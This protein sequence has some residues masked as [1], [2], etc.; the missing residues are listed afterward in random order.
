[1]RA[2]DLQAERIEP[3]NRYG[4][5]TSGDGL[6]PGLEEACRE[7]SGTLFGDTPPYLDHGRPGALWAAHCGEPS[8]Y[9][10]R[11]DALNFS[12][13]LQDE[14]RETWGHTFNRFREDDPQDIFKEFLEGDMTA[15]L[16]RC[17]KCHKT[18]AVFYERGDATVS[19]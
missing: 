4:I 11:L 3:L 13:E 18:L 12:G 2:K 9:L 10:G 16:F 17:A 14:L 15:H 6:F 1:M 8:I 7:N 19:G 5:L